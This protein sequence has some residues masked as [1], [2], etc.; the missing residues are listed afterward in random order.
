MSKPLS[1][2][3]PVGIREHVQKI[4]D[5]YRDERASVAEISLAVDAEMLLDGY[6]R[7]RAEN[8]HLRDESEQ[9]VNESEQLRAS[10]ERLREDSERLRTQYEWLR[11]RL[12]ASHAA[13]EARIRPG[14]RR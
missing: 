12:S 3:T 2:I 6:D 1:E 14:I 9:L 4:H 13:L 8:D 10:S 5:R 7:L 11:E